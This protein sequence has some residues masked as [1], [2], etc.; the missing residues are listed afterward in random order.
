MKVFTI[1][2][3]I[4]SE[5]AFS[6][7]V[8]IENK[9]RNRLADETLDAQQKKYLIFGLCQCV[10]RKGILVYNPLSLL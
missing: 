10:C 1:P 4:E 6:A 9:M 5:R 3:N 7:A 8:F 2:T